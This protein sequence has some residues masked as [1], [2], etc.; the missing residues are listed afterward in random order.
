MRQPKTAPPQSPSSLTLDDMPI[1]MAVVD[2]LHCVLE[3]NAAFRSLL[4]HEAE[5]VGMS[6]REAL[7]RATVVTDDG[8]FG[9]VYSVPR[10]GIEASYRLTTQSYRDGSIAMLT[11][12]T[13]ARETAERQRVSEDVRARLMHDAEIGVWRYDPDTEIYYFPTELSLGHGDIGR[14]VP[15]A[16]LRLLQHRDDQAKDDAIRERITHQGGA[17]SLRC[18]SSI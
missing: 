3:T 6:L 5:P 16:T 13:A 4:G 14:P 8:D 15:L 17:A 12:V 2:A 11:D 7:A 10:D 9:K 18:R 1:A